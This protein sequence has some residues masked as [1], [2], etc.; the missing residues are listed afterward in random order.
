MLVWMRRHAG[1]SFHRGYSSKTQ[2]VNEVKPAGEFVENFLHGSK[3]VGIV[4]LPNIGKST[5]FNALTR[6]QLAETMNRPFT[7]ITPNIAKVP[8][9]D[10]RAEKLEKITRLPVKPFN[11]EF[12]DIAGLVAGASKG[13]GLGNQFLSNIRGVSMIAHVVRFFD[14]DSI[15]HVEQSVDPLR[16]VRIIH[17][18]LILSDL[19][20]L[21]KAC[22]NRKVE[23]GAKALLEQAMK[24]LETE[25]LIAQFPVNLE[26]LKVLRQYDLL[27][28]K[29]QLYVFNVPETHFNDPEPVTM[30]R[31]EAFKTQYV[32][33]PHIIL[34]SKLEA[35][36]A[37]V[38]DSEE[39]A[40]LL[41]EYGLKEPCMQAFI[42]ASRKLLLQQT[43]FT[44]GLRGNPDIPNY[45]WPLPKY[46]TAVDA[47]GV[48]HSDLAK[49][50]IRAQVVHWG[51]LTSLESFDATAKIEGR[52]YVVKDGDILYF[53]VMK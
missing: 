14:D 52:D 28:L 11:V 48:V 38:R 39:Q 8:A 23:P 26:Q 24:F 3:A 19:A 33:C 47:A 43:F 13:L 37:L 32:D 40:Q 49:K 22:K 29:P 21:E 10:A 5:L 30:Q 35:E 51:D 27:T 42:S 7:T 6:S 34:A 1:G 4:G 9:I 53:R 31:I 36:L 17:A 20:T 2:K 46:S 18:E 16:D 25:N 45:M 12:V 50:F 44:L 41:A 15:T